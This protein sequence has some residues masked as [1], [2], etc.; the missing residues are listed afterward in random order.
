MQVGVVGISHKSSSLSLREKLARAFQ[1]EFRETPRTILLSTCNRT[2]L[3]F[4]AQSLADKQIEILAHLREHVT[5]SFEHALYSYFRQD[6]F[7]HLG[8]VI[9]GIDSAILG[10]SDIQRQVKL[11]YEEARKRGNLSHELHYL[12]QKGLKIGKEMRTSFLL[13]K[14]GIPLPFAVASILEGNRKILK[15]CRVLFVGNSSINRTLMGFFKQKGCTQMTLCTRMTEGDFPV[16]DITHWNGLEEWNHYDVVVCGTNHDRFV[17][18]HA[19][20]DVEETLLF[21]LSVPRN[22]NPM[23]ARHPNLKL[24]NIDQIGELARKKK[25]EKE[26]LLCENVI[27]KAVERQMELFK[28]RRQAKWRYA[29]AL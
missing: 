19:Q 15:H 28:E 14:Q 6:C 2:E 18:D 8:K 20:Q 24:Y 1:K 13:T 29:A 7:Q 12:F 11:A 10:E 17:I 9:S 21:D 4:C 27:E 26:I 22:I 3:Y 23:L 25:D 16:V 5:A